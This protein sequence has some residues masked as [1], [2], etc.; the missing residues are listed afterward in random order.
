MSQSKAEFF[1]KWDALTDSSA[2]RALAAKGHRIMLLSDDFQ[3][4]IA[5]LLEGS[6]IDFLFVENGRLTS[7]ANSRDRP[8]SDVLRCKNFIRTL[9]EEKQ[10]HVILFYEQV[11]KNIIDYNIA[12][13]NSGICWCCYIE[14][15]KTELIANVKLAFDELYPV[16]YPSSE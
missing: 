16:L 11:F 2:N 9:D 14:N 3:L 12:F 1:L 5:V 13:E 4:K 15:A 6:A 10:K 8:L 7:K